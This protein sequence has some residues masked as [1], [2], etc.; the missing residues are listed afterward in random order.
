MDVIY[1]RLKKQV[2]H[3]HGDVTFDKLGSIVATCMEFVEHNISDISG[4]EKEAWVVEAVD[5][6]WYEQTNKH[7]TSEL[8]KKE[9]NDATQGDIEDLVRQLIQQVCIATKGGLQINIT[10]ELKRV[11]S[12]RN[13]KSFSMK[14]KPTVKSSNQSSD[15]DN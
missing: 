11:T 4:P 5:K 1:N 8:K 12:I 3:R 6:I 10:S 13:N 15:R 14:R 9:N 7:I 2:E